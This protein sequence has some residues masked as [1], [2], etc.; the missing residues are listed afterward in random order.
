MGVQVSILI[1]IYSEGA[2]LG[3]AIES[4]LAQTFSN[5]EI[6]LV[7]NNAFPETRAIG[8]HYADRY[9]QL[10]RLIHEPKQGVCSA[11]NTGIKE[12]RGPYIAL[13]D[14]DDIMLPDRVSMQME[15]IKNFPDLSLVSSWADRV[16]SDNKFIVRKGSNKTEPIFW[17]ETEKIL[18]ELFPCS[19][20]SGN[21]E[22]LKFPLLSTCMFKKETAISAGG[23][24]T[25]FDPRWWEDFEFFL[26]MYELGNFYC[27]PQSLIRY[28]IASQDVQQIKDNQVD[29]M[30]QVRNLDV[31]YRIL[32][33]RHG[34]SIKRS[35]DVFRKLKSL[36]LRQI[37]FHFFSYSSGSGLGRKLLMRSIK[38]YPMDWP[39]WKLIAKSFFPKSFY[40]KLF[41]ISCLREGPLPDGATSEFVEKIISYD[42]LLC[43]ERSRGNG[44]S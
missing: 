15:V 10:I 40:P 36:W 27:I 22:T 19:P 44:V 38:S 39:S 3:E 23:F 11:R 1:P 16:S 34:R 33:E 5:I 6:V 2:V 41:W 7:D 30:T 21:G 37:S 29:W 12:C 24:N 13:L 35:N 31:F 4:A 14:G 32:I 8:K 42:Q 20:F 17:F 18:R 26:R 43:M 9:P 25:L 28:R